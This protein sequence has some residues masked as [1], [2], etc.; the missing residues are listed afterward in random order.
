MG[1]GKN[2]TGISQPRKQNQQASETAAYIAQM[3][4]ELASMARKDNLVM[5][6]FLLEMATQ[7]ARQISSTSSGAV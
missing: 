4:A 3:S 5:L 7:E 2:E 1:K 6:A